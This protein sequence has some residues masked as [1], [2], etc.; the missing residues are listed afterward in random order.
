MGIKIRKKVKSDK[1]DKQE[2]KHEKKTQSGEEKKIDVSLPFEE[3][4]LQAA[5]VPQF[6]QIVNH[7]IQITLRNG[8]MIKGFFIRR[9]GKHHL[10]LKD[11]VVIRYDHAMES[12]WLI[13]SLANISHIHPTVCQDFIDESSNFIF[14]E[15]AFEEIKKHIQIQ[16]FDKEGKEEELSNILRK[17]WEYIVLYPDGEKEVLNSLQEL[18]EY[19]DNDYILKLNE[20]VEERHKMTQL[21]QL[22]EEEPAKK[23][24][25]SKEEKHPKE[26]VDPFNLLI[27]ALPKRFKN[28]KTIQVTLKE[29]IGKQGYKYCVQVIETMNNLLKEG[30]IEES[31][32]RKT[33]IESLK[34]PVFFDLLSSE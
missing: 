15:P 11:A 6:L 5:S 20:Y 1:Q 34:N 26:E 23:E 12:P 7:N 2:Q 25:P 24:A 29:T 4:L 9:I 32:Y 33:M 30:R 19:K 21:S 14:V 8:L 28:T 18:K 27:E 13:V 3:K 31:I 10:L 16:Y 17:L 22:S